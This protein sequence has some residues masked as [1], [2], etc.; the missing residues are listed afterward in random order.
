L[1]E[2]LVDVTEPLCNQAWAVV[3][4]VPKYVLM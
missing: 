2:A 1:A 3:L 4:L